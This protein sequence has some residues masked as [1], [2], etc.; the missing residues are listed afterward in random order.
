MIFDH[1]IVR[2][3]IAVDDV[4]VMGI[5]QRI[6]NLQHQS[7]H[8]LDR[9]EPFGW[10]DVFLGPAD[11]VG[12]F[13]AFDQL[14]GE[15]EELFGFAHLVNRDDVWMRQDGGR[16]GLLLEKGGRFFGDHGFGKNLDGN[17]TFEAF[18]E[19]HE[20]SRHGA[21]P[22]LLQQHGSSHLLANQMIQ[23]ELPNGWHDYIP[24]PSMTV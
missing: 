23:I 9:H 17:L 11:I 2:F 13:V 19:G 18:L 24:I 12:E 1:D 22:Q 16:F 5:G 15:K 20:H 21:V 14:H 3:D 7:D 8:R 4:V 6:E 10:H